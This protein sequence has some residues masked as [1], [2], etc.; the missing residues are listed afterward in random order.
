MLIFRLFY[1]PNNYNTKEPERSC[2]EDWE[3]RRDKKKSTKKF[4][5]SRRVHRE[6]SEGNHAKCTSRKLSWFS[7]FSPHQYRIQRWR[8]TEQRE[9]SVDSTEQAINIENRLHVVTKNK[10]IYIKIYH[11]IPT[12]L[13]EMPLEYLKNYTPLEWGITAISG[14]NRKKTILTRITCA[15]FKINVYTS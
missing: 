13:A 14:F 15:S 7:F 6:G 1:L 8:R 3:G 11:G 5:S 9:E 10:E 2:W 4:I 12:I